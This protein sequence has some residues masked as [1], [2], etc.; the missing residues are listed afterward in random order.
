MDPAPDAGGVDEAPDLAADL[1]LLVDGVAGGASELVDDH[2]LLP[3]R[4]VQQRRLAHI[5]P[6]DDGYTARTADL[7]LGD[8][9]DLRECLQHVVEQVRDA[10]TVQR[11]DG[12]RLAEAQ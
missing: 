12:A 11:G 6:P 5:G 1:D 9:G 10:A 2:A 4:L 8:R 7:L 3:R